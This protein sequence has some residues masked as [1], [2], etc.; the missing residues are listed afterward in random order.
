[1]YVGLKKDK[2]FSKQTAQTALSIIKAS[3]LPLPSSHPPPYPLPDLEDLTGVSFKAYS[4]SLD[5]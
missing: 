2:G 1:M 3:K 4:A 5:L